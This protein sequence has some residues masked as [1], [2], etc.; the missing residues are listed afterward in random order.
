M[1]KARFGYLIDR[2]TA[3]VVFGNDQSQGGVLLFWLF[4]S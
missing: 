2:E 1:C 3:L 4:E